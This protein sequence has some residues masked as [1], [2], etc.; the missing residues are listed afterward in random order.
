MD[1]IENL[2]TPEEIAILKKAQEKITKIFSESESKKNM[3]DALNF[4]DKE[5]LNSPQSITNSPKE[6]IFILKGIAREI[7]PD[8]T[9]SDTIEII[10]QNYHI[11]VN[12]GT[13]YKDYIEKFLNKFRDKLQETCQE[14]NNG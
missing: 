8:G 11:P 13:K 12:V 1:E 5:Y 9:P 4:T 10:E 7:N 2:L 14:I 6:L 3:S